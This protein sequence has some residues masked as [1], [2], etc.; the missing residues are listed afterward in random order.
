MH[1]HR[2][3]CLQVLTHTHAFKSPTLMNCCA[4]NLNYIN[5]GAVW[6]TVESQQ[7]SSGL[8]SSWGLSVWNLHVP[9]VSPWASLHIPW[10]LS[11]IQ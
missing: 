11:T 3:R 8:K 6:C 9:P 10:L 1:E 2:H 5:G 4:H 7:E